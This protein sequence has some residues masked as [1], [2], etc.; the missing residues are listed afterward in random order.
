MLKTVVNTET[1]ITGG[2]PGTSVH[3]WI[4]NRMAAALPIEL[5]QL[6]KSV[7]YSSVN[8]DNGSPKL[9]TFFDKVTIPSSKEFNGSDT[10]LYGYGGS[11]TPWIL[12]D[13]YRIYVPGY[14]VQIA[15]ATNLK[16]TRPTS[17]KAGD[18]Y[19]SNTYNYPNYYNG[20]TWVQAA[21]VMTR[22]ADINSTNWM[23]IIPNGM[24]Y[25]ASDPSLSS[26]VVLRL[27]I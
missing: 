12:G 10:G 6:V 7:Q 18:M 2:F 13:R 8:Y 5:Q 26:T 27:S 11:K 17:P 21:Y 23:Y 1:A 3:N 9:A 19:I 24:L 16:D 20:H 25:A 22:D 4:T 15:Q 14:P